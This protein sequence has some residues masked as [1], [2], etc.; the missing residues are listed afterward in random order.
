MAVDMVGLANEATQVGRHQH[1]QEWRELAECVLKT[2]DK[3]VSDW[4]A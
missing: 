4:Y 3:I 1:A 2:A